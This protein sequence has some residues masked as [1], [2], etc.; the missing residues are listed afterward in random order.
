MAKISAGILL[1]RRRGSTIDVLLVHPGGPFWK[2]RDAGS[3]TIPKGE[4]EDGEDAATC[5]RREFVEEVGIDPAGSLE[6]LGDIVQRGGKRV[7][8]FAMEGDQLIADF[9]SNSFDM[10][11]PPR[12]GRMQSFPEIDRVEWMSPAEARAKINPAQR[13][14]IDRLEALIG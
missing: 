4:L 13:D 1:Y 3:W 10:E 11:W 9:R 8:A 2:N 5:A 7:I 6:P 14:L 12:S